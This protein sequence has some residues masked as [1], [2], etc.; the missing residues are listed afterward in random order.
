MSLEAQQEKL[1]VKLEESWKAVLEDE[2]HK[3]YFL[4]MVSYLKE[5]KAKGVIIY[6][7]GPDIFSAFN[8][9]P[10][11]KVKVVLLGQDPYHGARQANGLSFSVNPGIRQPP[12]LKNIFKELHDDT[13]VPIPENGDLSKWAGEG[14][15]LLNAILTVEANSAASHQQKGWEEFTDAVI[16]I[17]SDKKEG[18]VFLLWGRFAQSK[19]ELID[20]SRHYILNAAHPSP[21]ARG[22]FFGSKPF[23][24]TNEILRN[25]GLAAIDWDLSK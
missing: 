20:K 22:A 15:L 25:F 3:P 1:S 8:L 18:I 10:F 19:E 7:K 17:L 5:Q 14:V 12:S 24:K 16:K 6:P 21:L 9:T 4:K 11:K 23:S 13:G 2:F